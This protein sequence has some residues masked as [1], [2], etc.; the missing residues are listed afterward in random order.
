MIQN[1]VAHKTEKNEQATKVLCVTATLWTEVISTV[2]TG[3][4]I[5]ACDSVKHAEVRQQ[6]DMAEI[7]CVPPEG[8][9]GAD[10]GHAR[11]IISG[12]GTPQR[13]PGEAA[14][15]GC[16]REVLDSQL[17]LLRARPGRTS[18]SLQKAEGY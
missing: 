12:L 13:V 1:N 14:G 4:L 10:P 9:P 17:R 3:V 7:P 18:V 2:D 16:E 15:G 5:T 8:G 6:R 11:E